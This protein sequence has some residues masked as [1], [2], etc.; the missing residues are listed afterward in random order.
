M[1]HPTWRHGRS[2]AVSRRRYTP[3]RRITGVIAFVVTLPMVFVVAAVPSQAAATHHW[4]GKVAKVQDGDT[5]YVKI[6]GDGLKRSVPIRNSGIQATEVHPKV[7][8]HGKAARHYLRGILPKGTKVR[9]S[10]A[11]KN[12]TAGVDGA[13]RVRYWRYIDKWVK[14][15]H[16]WVDVQALLL[17]H[18]DVMWL[19][20]KREG[21]RIAAY[22]RYMQEGMAKHIG[23]WNNDHCGT[24]PAQSANLRMWL[25]YDANGNDKLVKNGE[26]MRI[27]NRG[28][29]DVSIA[30]WKLRNASKTFDHGGNYYTLPKGSVVPA[31]KTITFFFGSG[32]TNPSAGRFYLGLRNTQYLGNVS[33]PRHG[34]PGKTIY[35]LDPQYDFRFV[36]DYP[37]LVGCAADPPV[38][39]SNVS[40]TSANDEYVD[41]TVKS[42]YSSADLSGVVVE[43]DG[44]TK[45]IAPGTILNSGETLRLW[46]DKAGTDQ[47]SSGSGSTLNQYW[48]ARSGTMLADSGD[49]VNLRTAQ[50]HVL[51]TYTY[52]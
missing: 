36:A 11:H 14:S 15:T 38:Q 34:Y 1:S 2:S 4:Y 33:N 17:R 49:T 9:L 30:G 35:L 45:E 41:L 8:C 21:A 22:H 51:D 50:S 37:C 31:G 52:G 39:I 13:G 23:L 46:C 47:K 25:N 12:S 28:K 40:P 10:A 5:V 27:Q 7:E 6:K 20:H 24:G 26:W 42:G 32:T 43:N 48:G 29:S 19:A 16:S 44:W 3:M 18:G